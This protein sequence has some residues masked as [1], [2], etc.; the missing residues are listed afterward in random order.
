M[1]KILRIVF[2]MLKN[3]SKYVVEVDSE[4]IKQYE[5]KLEKRKNSDMKAHAAR[6]L[7]R[8]RIH[9]N[10]D[11]VAPIS[12]TEHKKRRKYESYISSQKKD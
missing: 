6:E 2:M 8:K 5:D 10:F 12:M 4:T 7:K 9:Q 3:K 11:S 1:N